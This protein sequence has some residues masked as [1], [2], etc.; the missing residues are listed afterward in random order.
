MTNNVAKRLNPYL[1]DLVVLYAKFHDL[2]WFVKGKMFVEVHK[3]TES[4]Y[5]DFA[6]KLDEVAEK[7]IMKGE[8]PVSTLKD[9]LELA[10]VKE[11]GKQDYT[12]MEVLE[13]VLKDT[14]YLYEEAKKL[15]ASFA[16]EDDY[17]VVNMLED[18][19]AGYEKELW[20]LR[21]MMK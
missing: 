20:F 12:E 6:A 18:H 14:E 5:D 1:S 8:K 11:L 21:S 13:E 16:E 2:H 9:Y 17:S 4:R 7:V 15:R 19:I 10:T 3:Y